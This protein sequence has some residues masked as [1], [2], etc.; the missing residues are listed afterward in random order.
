MT[1]GP[2]YQLLGGPPVEAIS[3]LWG[4][5]RRRQKPWTVPALAQATSVSQ[6]YARTIIGLLCRT[7]VVRVVR[8]SRR[9]DTGEWEPA[10]YEV[11]ARM[12]PIAPRFR[13]R[14]GKGTEPIGLVDRNGHMR[15]SEFREARRALGLSATAMA[16]ELGYKD[17]RVV[18]RIEA[19]EGPILPIFEARVR[20]LLGSAKSPRQKGS[21]VSRRGA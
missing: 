3:R 10:V 15:S 1:S 4:Y 12:G 17:R 18:L 8:P 2:G 13:R 9:A 6:R 16:A 20:E 5:L 19:G 11:V 21:R 7:G 14:S